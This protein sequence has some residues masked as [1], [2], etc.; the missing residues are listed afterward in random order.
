M[1]AHPA[2]TMAV[3]ETVRSV[4]GE[5]VSAGAGEVVVVGTLRKD[6]D[7]QESLKETAGRLYAG[8]MEVS[9]EGVNGG[10]G[11]CVRLPAYAW[12]HQ[13]FWV[14]D[15]PGVRPSRGRAAASSKGHPLLGH[16]LR[17]ALKNIQYEFEFSTE[18]L[19]YL[20][21]HRI[22]GTGGSRVVVPA[23]SHVSMALSALKDSFGSDRCA[24]EDVTFHQALV[25]SEG[26]ARVGQMILTQEESGAFTFEVFSSAADEDDPEWVL[27]ARGRAKSEQSGDAGVQESKN[28]VEEIQSRNAEEAAGADYY[29]DLWESGYHLGDEFR[30]IGKIRRSDGEALSEIR[31]GPAPD[32]GGKYQLHPGLI[33][34]CFQTLGL[35]LAA[36]GSAGHIASDKIYI[37]LSVGSVSF[38]GPAGEGRLWCHALL[39]EFNQEGLIVGDLRLLDEAGRVLAEIGGLCLRLVNR[40]AVSGAQENVSDWLYEVRW[41]AQLPATAAAGEGTVPK[42]WLILA[43]GKGVGAALAERLRGSGHSCLLAFRG[44]GFARNSEE[45][46]TLDPSDAGAF[47]RLWKEA[48]EGAEETRHGVVHLW[49]LDAAEEGPAPETLKQAQLLCSGSA[50]HTLHALTDGATRPRLWLV[51]AGAHNVEP[52]DGAASVAQSGVWGLGRVIAREHPELRCTRIDLGRGAQESEVEGLFNE[53][54]GDGREDELAFRKAGRYA[55][56]LMRPE[57]AVLKSLSGNGAQRPAVVREDATYLVTGG[58]GGLGLTVARWLVKEGARHLVLVGRSEASDAA[59]E[60]L[61]E[62]EQAGAEVFVAQA[63]VSRGEDVSELLTKVAESMPPLRGIVH[64]AG[65]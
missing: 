53:L 51:T 31:P 55:A 11:R 29:N 58:L 59:R 50:L 13:R 65:V 47:R 32:G 14:E 4:A 15:V 42:R 43:D 23:S 2:L 46:W 38:N 17:S 33:D 21:D 27:H 45:E 37:P 62:L 5:G 30:W 8:G 39:R 22:E 60:V 18:A 49:S 40:T 24:L 44:E 16:R 36:A 61:G 28:S 63:D 1:S 35:A 41:E 7:E 34:S 20:N 26:E 9:W 48:T 52:A 54:L 10:R 12:Q 19:P 3:E 64:A 57:A 6:M 56:R 25:L